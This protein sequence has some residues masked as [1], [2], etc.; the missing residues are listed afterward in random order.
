MTWLSVPCN[1]I[2]VVQVAGGTDILKKSMASFCIPTSKISMMID[3]H[4]YDGWPAM[5]CLEE[6]GVCCGKNDQQI[7]TKYVGCKI[8]NSSSFKQIGN[9]T[10]VGTRSFRNPG[11][12]CVPAYAST[13]Q[14]RN[15]SA[16][17]ATAFTRVAE[18]KT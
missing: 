13:I 3:M 16:G 12:P 5:F 11:E 9:K 2:A 15:W 6:L 4:A 10:L 14:V 7:K 8:V 17:S 1:L 18:K